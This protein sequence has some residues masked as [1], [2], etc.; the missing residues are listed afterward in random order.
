MCLLSCFFESKT[1]EE[2]YIPGDQID[3]FIDLCEDTKPNN[4]RSAVLT[5]INT[6]T[7]HDFDSKKIRTSMPNLVIN[8]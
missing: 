8:Q 1:K 3:K 6:S 2:K 7:S 4:M 5:K